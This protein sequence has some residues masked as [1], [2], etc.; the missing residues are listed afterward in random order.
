AKLCGA[1]PLISYG[2]VET[3]TGVDFGSKITYACFNGYKL[4]GNGS[5][6]CLATGNWSTIPSCNALSSCPQLNIQSANV[7]WSLVLNNG[8]S[9][10]SVYNFTCQQ[11]YKL[12]GSP[13]LICQQN[14][15][16]SGQLPTCQRRLCPV[17]TISQATLK[18]N[19]T[20]VYLG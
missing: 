1:A 13:T 9:I 16:W 6:S 7:T 17:P 2:F 15:T 20:T 3:S 11:G 19:A 14:G 8:T 18:T 4:S 5:V 10:G 12:I